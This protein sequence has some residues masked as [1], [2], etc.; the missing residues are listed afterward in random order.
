MSAV[1]P[2]PRL[3]IWLSSPQYELKATNGTVQFPVAVHNVSDA[4]VDGDFRVESP[5]GWDVQREH[6]TFRVGPQE[7]LVVAFRAVV[8]G[9]KPGVLRLSAQIGD[10]QSL[11]LASS[12]E[13]TTR[14]SDK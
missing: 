10:R 11:P 12:L 7:R 4:P 9:G 3:D 5:K 6:S 8:S 14:P 1:E 2:D 13:A